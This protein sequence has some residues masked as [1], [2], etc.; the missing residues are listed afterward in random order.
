MFSACLSVRCCGHSNIGNFNQILSKFHI[1]I[2]FTNLWLKFE[3][4]FCPTNNNQDGQQ[5]GHH[6]SVCML[7]SLLVIFNR[8]SSKFHIWIAFIKLSG[9]RKPRWLTKWPPPISLHLWTLYLSHLLPD[10]FPILYMDYTYQILAQ[11]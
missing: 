5:N 10:C 6:L 9:E 4:G 8:I 7:W 11:V 2:A 1:W 3:Y